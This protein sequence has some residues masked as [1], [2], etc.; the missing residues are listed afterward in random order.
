MRKYFVRNG[1]VAL[2][3]P[4]IVGKRSGIE[5]PPPDRLFKIQ[6]YEEKHAWPL[7]RR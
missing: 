1:C 2:P 5:V 7:K 6:E 4:G 3:R